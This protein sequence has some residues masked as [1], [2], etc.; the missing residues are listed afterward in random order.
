MPFQ[1]PFDIEKGGLLVGVSRIVRSCWIGWLEYLG[2]EAFED[3]KSYRVRLEDLATAV[4]ETTDGFLQ[5]DRLSAG[6]FC[7]DLTHRTLVAS[8]GI[9]IEETVDRGFQKKFAILC[10]ALQ[11][12]APDTGPFCDLGPNSDFECKHLGRRL[13]AYRIAKVEHQKQS[14]E[15]TRQGGSI[16]R[17]QRILRYELLDWIA[18]GRD[19]F[20]SGWP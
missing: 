4:F 2:D 20:G 8:Q 13:A 19:P 9:R 15:Q 6:N 10:F 1:S 7:S 16:L 5:K 14:Q 11:V 17:T 3:S 12:V 18:H